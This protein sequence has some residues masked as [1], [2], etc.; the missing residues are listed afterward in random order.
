MIVLLVVLAV[1]SVSVWATGSLD[2]ALSHGHLNAYDCFIGP[3]AEDEC[4]TPTAARE[5]K[6]QAEFEAKYKHRYE[7]SDEHCVSGI[8]GP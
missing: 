6:E 1:A 5:C 3:E 8:L 4:G 2:S 7:V